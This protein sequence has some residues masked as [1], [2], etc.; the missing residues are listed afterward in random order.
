MIERIVSGGQTG[1]DRA[2]LE[3]AIRHRITHCGWCPAGRMAED[4]TISSRYQLRETPERSYSQR[5]EWN[6]RDS[7]GTVI[8]SIRKELVGGSQL[9]QHFAQ[10]HDKPFLHLSREND[11]FTAAEKLREFIKENRINILNVAGPRSSTEPEVE[12]F[13][14]AVLLA[15]LITPTS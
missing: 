10:L 5:T 12:D 13:T 11:T 8:F 4:G 7:D 9:T 14:N 3:F 1:A 15:A 6:V 2:A